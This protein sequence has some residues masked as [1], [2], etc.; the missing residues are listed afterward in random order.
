MSKEWAINDY[1]KF[2]YEL[3]QNPDVKKLVSDGK[4]VEE[5]PIIT[6]NER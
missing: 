4:A 1:K 2:I 5:N 6:T 3:S